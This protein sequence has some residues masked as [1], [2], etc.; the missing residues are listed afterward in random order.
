MSSTAPNDRT[1]LALT[2][3]PVD[4]VLVCTFTAFALTSFCVDSLAALDLLRADSPI[5][6]AR[7]VYDYAQRFDPLVGENPLFL[8][9]MSGLSAFVFGPFYV[10][11]IQALIRGRDWI[12]IPAL[13]YG[14][15]MSYSMIVHVL[16]ELLGPMPPPNLAVFFSMYAPYIIAPLVLMFRMRSPTPFPTTSSVLRTGIP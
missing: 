1:V 11:L 12:R 16:V 5:H 7:L 14:A 13:L 6:L 8:R 3:R 10:V 15:A 9:V 4:L 2:R